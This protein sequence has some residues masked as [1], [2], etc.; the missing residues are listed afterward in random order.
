M[1]NVSHAS[2]TG[3]EVHE[4]KGIVSATLGTVYVS[5]GS[6]SGSWQNVGTSS[7]TGMVADFIAPIVPSGWLELDGSII[8]TTTFA[9]LYAVMTI[10]TTGSRTNASPTITSIAD[11]STFRVGYFAFGTGIPTN[12]T[13]ISIDSPTQVTLSNNATSSGTSAFAVSPWK[14]N[15]GTIQLPDVSS[16]GRYRR[17]RTPSTAVGQVQAD[18]FAS[19]THT[20]STGTITGTTDS[21]G[22][23]QHSVFLKDPGHTHTVPAQSNVVTTDVTGTHAVNGTTASGSST[24]GI[25]IGSVNGTAN[26][27]LTASAGAHT[28]NVSGSASVSLNSTGGSET[29]PVSLIVMTCVKT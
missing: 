24:T 18:S 12:T 14:L 28:H 7:F 8:S 11:T 25:T 23:H 17:S 19:H 6:G 16:A 1:T 22:A 4:P 29:R 27:N 13:I 9:N 21:Q 20:Q 2:L 26:D 10:A 5:N 15:T 3:S